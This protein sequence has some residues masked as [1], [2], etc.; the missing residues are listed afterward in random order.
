M[1]LLAVS[2][3]AGVLTVLAPCILPLLPVVLGTAAAGRSKA[4]PYIVVGSLALSIILFTYLLKFST[5]LIMIPP[6]VWT[7]FTGGVLVL[8]GLILVF[9]ALWEKVPGVNRLSTGSNKLVGTGYQKKSFWG[10]VLIGAALGPVFSSCSPT[11]FVILASVLPA[12]FALGSLYLFAYAAGLA[13]IL[14]LVALLGQRFADKLSGAANSRG[15]F[16]KAV[17]VLF[18]ALGVLIASGYE[19]KLE[20]A[21]LESGFV[22]VVNWEQSILQ[23]IE[24]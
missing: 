16:K 9:P 23:R 6:E 10:D 3:I 22:D 8:F 5:A 7:Y 14:L 24:I 13:L 2:F 18:I 20:V 12:S 1:A 21:I 15:W 17:G 19:K 11:Y 4:T